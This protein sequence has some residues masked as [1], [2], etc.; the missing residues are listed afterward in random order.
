[1]VLGFGGLSTTVAILHRLIR[2]YVY[3]DS[4]DL[5]TV[6]DAGGKVSFGMTAV[7]M[8]SQLLWPADFLQ[9]ATLMAKVIYEN[10][11]KPSD[12]PIPNATI[13]MNNILFA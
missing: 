6:F 10:S 13:L 7:T 2:K 1:M 9:Q 12:I 5:D 3:K 11:S 4:H 8:T